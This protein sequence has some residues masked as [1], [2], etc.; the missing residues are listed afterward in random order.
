MMNMMLRAGSLY[1][2]ILV[3][4]NADY[5]KAYVVQILDGDKQMSMYCNDV[6]LSLDD[7][8]SVGTLTYEGDSMRVPVWEIDVKNRVAESMRIADSVIIRA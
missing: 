7:N 2:D 8:E 4:Y 3:L 6:T 1:K 5:T